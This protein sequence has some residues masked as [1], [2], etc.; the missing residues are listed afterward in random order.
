[1]GSN[2]LLVNK[3]KGFKQLNNS[4]IQNKKSWKSGYIPNFAQHLWQH[5]F[6]SN[7]RVNTDT[8]VY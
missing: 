8:S 3:K 7:K 5:C 1:M 2:Y 4:K 6:C